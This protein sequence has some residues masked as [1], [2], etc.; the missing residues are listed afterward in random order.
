MICENFRLFDFQFEH[1]DG[2][3]IAMRSIGARPVGPDRI[4]TRLPSRS[5]V[6]A[7]P[8]TRKAAGPGFLID[9]GQLGDEVVEDFVG[10]HVSI[11]GV[12]P[13][14]DQTIVLPRAA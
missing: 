7:A 14:R 6:L 8:P 9:A 10:V 5:D 3:K 4:P 2:K 12:G 11:V 13:A 1:E